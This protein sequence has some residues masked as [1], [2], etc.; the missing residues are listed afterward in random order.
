MIHNLIKS[1]RESALAQRKRH[2][3]SFGSNNQF[4]FLDYVAGQNQQGSNG[5]PVVSDPYDGLLVYTRQGLGEFTVVNPVGPQNLTFGA[6]KVTEIHC[7][8][9]PL[10]TGITCTSDALLTVL[11]LEDLPAM[12]NLIF[13]NC[14]SLTSLNLDTFTSFAG[15]LDFD[16]C[17]SLSS[18][19]FA[20]LVSVVGEFR[21][22]ICALT[23]VSIPLLQT[24]ASLVFGSSSTITSASFPSFTDASSLVYF[25]FDPNLTTLS[26]P[27][28]QTTPVVYL[29][30][31]SSI[32]SI[33]LPALETVGQLL[34]DECPSLVSIDISSLQSAGYISAYNDVSLLSFDM[35]SYLGALPNPGVIF[36]L[37]SSL[38]T[39]SAGTMIASDGAQYFFD[40][41]DLLQA[42]VNNLIQSLTDGGTTTSELDTSGGTSAAPDAGHAAQVIVLNG[43][44]NIVSTN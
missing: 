21:F 19:S 42:S 27:L 20:S 1:A 32:V 11:D 29:N 2:P 10:I 39:F 30:D 25:S 17:T 14:T 5:Q 28:L 23:V 16:S 13:N 12:A 36:G 34:I 4:T 22:N 26:L 38:N 9:C 24:A 40:G 7:H 37:C 41:C 6:N 43:L 31:C 44:G 33:S 15:T 35:P 3:S 8:N 18:I